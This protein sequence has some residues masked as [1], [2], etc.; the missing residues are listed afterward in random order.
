MKDIMLGKLGKLVQMIVGLPP[1]MFGTLI[2]LCEKLSSKSDGGRW[3]CR[4]KVMLRDG[5]DRNNTDT[6]FLTPM[7][8]VHEIIK[9]GGLGEVFNLGFCDPNFY[10]W[11]NS[12]CQIPDEPVELDSVTI[13]EELQ[14]HHLNFEDSL[15]TKTTY[16]TWPI[17]I[18]R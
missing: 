15:L 14:R 13:D 6:V 7:L 1:K 11:F 4:L 9:K 16:W 17:E 18:F 5:V 3:F 8:C 2:D 10:D 12:L